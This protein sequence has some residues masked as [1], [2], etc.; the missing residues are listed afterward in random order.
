MVTLYRPCTIHVLAT[1]KQRPSKSSNR[2]RLLNPQVTTE[3]YGI[4][5]PYSYSSYRQVRLNERKSRTPGFHWCGTFILPLYTI[6][7]QISAQPRIGA[8]LE[9]G[10]FFRVVCRNLALLHLRVSL[11]PF[12]VLLQNKHTTLTENDENL[13]WAHSQ[14]SAHLE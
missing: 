10:V 8:H 11:L 1:R 6:F 5:I 9:D 13:I 14:I 12:I 2:K 7:I 3:L 4:S